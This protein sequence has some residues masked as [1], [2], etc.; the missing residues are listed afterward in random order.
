MSD[1]NKTIDPKQVMSISLIV[2]RKSSLNLEALHGRI[3][4]REEFDEKYASDPADF[5]SLRQFAEDNGLAVDEATSSLARRTLVVRGTASAMEKAFGVK[6]VNVST[7]DG[8]SSCHSFEGPVHLP[9]RYQ[10][11]IEAVLGL[12]TRPIATSHIS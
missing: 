12:D 2:R 5:A 1:T 3:L 10:P 9:A 8:N 6:L 11:L 4:S 7:D